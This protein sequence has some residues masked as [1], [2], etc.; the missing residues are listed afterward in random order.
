MLH[1]LVFRK[2]AYQRFEHLPNTYFLFPRDVDVDARELPEVMPKLCKFLPKFIRRRGCMDFS[3][4]SGPLSSRRK[5]GQHKLQA[6]TFRP[7]H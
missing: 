5:I 2:W 3:L 1:V 6:V 4:A 7:Q